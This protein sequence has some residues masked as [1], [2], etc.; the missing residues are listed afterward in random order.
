MKNLYFP[1]EIWL[2]LLSI[3]LFAAAYGI[4][5]VCFP[6]VLMS[7]GVDAKKIGLAFAIDISGGILMS[8]FLSKFVARLGILLSLRLCAIIYGAAILLIY[9]YQNF[10]LW[11]AFALIMG[12]IWFAYV[13]T[14]QSWLNMLSDKKNR[15]VI[16]GFFSLAISLGLAAGPVIVR[17]C[18]AINYLSFVIS[19]LLVAFSVLCL[20]PLKDHKQVQVEAKKI[21]LREFFKTNPRCFLGRFFLD[22]QTY[23]LMTG[24]VLFGHEIGLTPED[25]GLLITA[26]LLSCFADVIAGFLLKKNSAYKL[27]NI[28]FLLGLSCFLLVIFFHKSYAFLFALYFFFGV[29]IALIFV[30]VYKL[31]NDDY[32][33]EK[34][35]AANATFQIVGALGSISGSTIGGLLINFFGAVGFPL[36]M[37]LSSI[38]YLIFLVV[39]EKRM[40][41][42]KV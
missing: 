37:V 18:G 35:V 5:M 27:I 9:F 30:S 15:S 22:F 19:A 17:F 31:T 41:V 16:L 28:G 29:A 21:S 12:A 39:Y 3:F 7:H 36:A 32:S 40:I 13:I 10:Y 23:L 34:L 26:Y 6:S 2:I 24:S 20:Q 33:A 38:F 11:L 25:S 42:K 14:R 1:R 4:N 8:F